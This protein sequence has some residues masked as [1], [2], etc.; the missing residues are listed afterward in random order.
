[1]ILLN[2]EDRD[3]FLWLWCIHK[4]YKIVMQITMIKRDKPDSN[5]VFLW[6]KK[7]HFKWQGTYR[8]FKREFDLFVN[9]KAFGNG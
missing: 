8:Q 9:G 1:M 2:Y 4:K 3:C 5:S 6:D 7:M